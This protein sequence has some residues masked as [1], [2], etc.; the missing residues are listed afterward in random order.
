[1]FTSLTLAFRHTD[2]RYPPIVQ[3]EKSI[4]IYI[5]ICQP[6]TESTE[7]GHLPSI[8]I[9]PQLPL[10]FKSCVRTS[11]L[12]ACYMSSLIILHSYVKHT[13][14]HMGLQELYVNIEKTYVLE[15]CPLLEC[16]A[17]YSGKSLGTFRNTLKMGPIGCPKTSVRIYHYTA[18]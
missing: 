6:T 12:Y 15:I 2:M 3:P 5:Y 7:F 1:M 4:N 14:T 9:S 11:I 18:A 13:H 10:S 17:A 16:F 8:L